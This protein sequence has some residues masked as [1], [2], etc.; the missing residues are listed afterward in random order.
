MWTEKHQTTNVTINGKLD[1][2]S[3]QNKVLILTGLKG[4]KQHGVVFFLSFVQAS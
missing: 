2:P 4:T 3:F 1:F